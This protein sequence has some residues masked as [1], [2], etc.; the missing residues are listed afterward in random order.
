MIQEKSS[1]ITKMDEGK[2]DKMEEGKTQSDTKSQKDD[3]KCQSDEFQSDG[4]WTA[5]KR[6]YLVI[7]ILNM[8]TFLC[9]ASQGT[10]SISVPR[11]MS[12]ESR[13]SNDTSWPR[14]FEVTEEDEGWISE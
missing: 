14:D 8:V 2:T 7:A 13:G 9:G 3:L 11:L 10:A 4:F 1:S 5:T 6:Q 12:N